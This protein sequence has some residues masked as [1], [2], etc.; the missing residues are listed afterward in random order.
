MTATTAQPTANLDLAA[1]T[2]NIHII[3]ARTVDGV[4]FQVL[5]V[6]KDGVRVNRLRHRGTVRQACARAI[7]GYA[8]DT[9][10][11]FAALVA[12]VRG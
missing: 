2:R 11:D 4:G 12:A 1:Q 5:D 9:Q 8:H 7:L 3:P 6:Y 10:P